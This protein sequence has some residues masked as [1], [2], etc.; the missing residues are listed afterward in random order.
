VKFEPSAKVGGAWKR[1]SRNCQAFGNV[2]FLIVVATIVVLGGL[3]FTQTRHQHQQCGRLSCI[4]N[5]KQIGLGF[6]SWEIDYGAFP[7]GIS[8]SL[9]GSLEFTGLGD[10]YRHFQTAGLELGSPRI[11]LC[12]EDARRKATLDFTN[13]FGN[14][15]VSYFI[16]LDG[17]YRNTGQIL[18]GDRHLSTNSAILSSTQLSLD[19]TTSVQWTKDFHKGAGHV[20][21][22]DGSATKLSSREL[23]SSVRAGTNGV[24]RILFP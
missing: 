2:D 18:A 12:P 23:Q 9:G 10:S 13:G 7:M 15:N 24:Q 17:V 20:L 1:E 8:N 14:Q 11:L 21:F 19:N 4:N 22:T 16:N 6:R 5:L 3:W